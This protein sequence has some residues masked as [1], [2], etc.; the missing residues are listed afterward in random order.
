MVKVLPPLLNLAVFN[1]H[2]SKHGDC[3]LDTIKLNV[4]D[5]LRHD[6]S[7]NDADI[8]NRKLNCAQLVAQPSR[9]C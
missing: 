8:A 2:R 7:I 4:V 3:T 1:L 6:R 5:A 9:V